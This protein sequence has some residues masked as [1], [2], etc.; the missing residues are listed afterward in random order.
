MKPLLAL[1]LLSLLGCDDGPATQ[2][3]WFADRDR[4]DA[5]PA[6][7][8]ST[9]P[10]D[11]FDFDGDG[12]ADVL[13]GAFRPGPT[14]IPFVTYAEVYLG[15]ASGLSPTSTGASLKVGNLGGV[16]A[17]GDV[18]GDGRSDFFL[19]FGEVR[20]GAEPIFGHRIVYGD[21]NGAFDREV[22]LEYPPDDAAIPGRQPLSG[23][24]I[25]DVDGDGYD[26][27]ALVS[28]EVVI[29]IYF[30][31]PDGISTEA[32]VEM[33][34]ARIEPAGDVDGD[35]YDE[36]VVDMQLYYGSANGPEVSPALAWAPPAFERL[37]AALDA[38]ADGYSDL[39]VRGGTGTALTI[40][41]GGPSGIASLEH[42][43]PFEPIHRV[44]DWYRRIDIG[45][46]L[47]YRRAPDVNGDGTDELLSCWSPRPMGD[48]ANPVLPRDGERLAGFA[49]QDG[50][51]DGLHLDPWVVQLEPVPFLEADPA[52][53]RLFGTRCG[54]PGDVDGDGFAD[55]VVTAPNRVGFLGAFCVYYGGV[56]PMNRSPDLC[57]EDAGMDLGH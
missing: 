15:T 57:V 30:G 2:D 43:V 39:I 55:V 40:F 44:G 50:S 51:P 32:D 7:P 13:T 28:R 29:G 14:D 18:D 53:A 6:V 5:P 46:G 23:G 20:A 56:D 54:S 8:L 1:A 31:G 26:D 27:V 19:R 52:T 17:A 35:G 9:D 45:P 22:A 49:V 4:S 10:R 21:P 33:R 41:Y 34:G 12:I 47:S 37:V 42:G 25:G 24:P 3:G 48:P 11:H 36:V 16:A 38:D